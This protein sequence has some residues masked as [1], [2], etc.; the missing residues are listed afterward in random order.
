MK[1]KRSCI[2]WTSSPRSVTMEK[3]GIKREGEGRIK[4]GN[5]EMG[6]KGSCIFFLPK[7]FLYSS[8]WN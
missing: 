2:Y 7:L 8:A 1:K 5:W 4:K 3:N 6:K